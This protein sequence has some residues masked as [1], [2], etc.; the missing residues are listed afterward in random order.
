MAAESLTRKRVRKLEE[1]IEW[2]AIGRRKPYLPL[3]AVLRFRVMQVV[4]QPFA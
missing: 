3:A 2:A 1:G 4:N